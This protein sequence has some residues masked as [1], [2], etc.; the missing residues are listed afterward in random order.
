MPEPVKQNPGSVVVE[1]TYTPAQVMAGISAA[2]R[3]GD[4]PAVAS[5]LRLLAGVDPDSAAAI[6]AA[7]DLMSAEAAQ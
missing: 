2:L 7:V 6:L 3:A 5:L 1:P 4:M